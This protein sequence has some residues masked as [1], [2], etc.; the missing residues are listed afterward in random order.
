MISNEKAIEQQNKDADMIFTQISTSAI[1]NYAD[2]LQ[3]ICSFYVTDMSIS[4][5][6]ISLALNRL[7]EFYKDKS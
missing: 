7:E 2:A 3:L 4:R 6:G 1:D 5:A